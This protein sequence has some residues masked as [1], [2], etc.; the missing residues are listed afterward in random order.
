ML[1][2]NAIKQKQ[3]TVGLTIFWLEKW[4][5]MELKCLAQ[6]LTALGTKVK[7]MTHISCSV[8]VPYFL[9]QNLHDRYYFN[10]VPKY[11]FYVFYSFF[12][13]R[14]ITSPTSP[15]PKTVVFHDGVLCCSK[16]K[17][18]QLTGN[19]QNPESVITGISGVPITSCHLHYTHFL[20]CEFK[21]QWKSSA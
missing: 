4:E 19:W 9:Q 13:F 21:I 10:E 20:F 11:S 7:W 1:E 14:N 16:F 5:P 12:L 2:L 15:S 6:F 17:K 8:P 18:I 3:I